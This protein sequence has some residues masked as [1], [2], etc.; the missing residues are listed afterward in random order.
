MN[1]LVLSDTHGSLE[2]SEEM[3]RRI[4]AATPID[5][6]IHCGDH[7]KD[8]LRLSE[9][10]GLPVTAAHGNCDGQILREVVILETPAG[11]IGVTHGH[12]DQVEFSLQNL[13]Y[14]AEEYGCRV[15][16]F[17]H[18]HV[19]VNEVVDGIRLLNPGSLT[20]PRGGSKPSCGLI[21]TTEK[22]L[23]ATVMEF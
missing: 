3:F 14:T 2:R 11:K 20:N 4:N 22:S 23:A 7:Y 5:H 21:V 13:R 18:T 6:L 16:C 17:G 8:A 19:P 12:V 1:I 15:M 10:L 9:I